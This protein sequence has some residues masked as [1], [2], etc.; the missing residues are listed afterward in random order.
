[1]KILIVE[2]DILLGDMLKE[3]L[4]H[5]EHERVE[6]STTGRN[7]LKCIEEE[8]FDCVFV[9]L[10]LPDIF[11]V[12]LLNE[13]KRQD[14]ALPVIMM[15]GHPTMD[16]AMDAMRKGA[17]DFLTKPFTLQNLVLTLERVTKE[18]KLLMENLR[19][20]WESQT[21][22]QL[23]AVNQQLQERIQEQ[24]RLF[25]IA[26][27]LDEI[28]SDGDLYGRVA[29]ISSDIT[30]SPN[31]AVFLLPPE[32]DKLVLLAGHGMDG[33]SG[34]DCIFSAN[35]LQLKELAFE[36]AYPAACPSHEL[37]GSPHLQKYNLEDATLSC[38]PLKI[39]GELFGF[40]MT[41]RDRSSAA[42]SASQLKLMDFLTR[43]TSLA[44]ENLA[45]YENLISNFYGILRSLVNALEAKDPYTGKHSERV[46]L[47]A[48]RIALSM[49]SSPASI[50]SL[51][52]A[53]YLHDIGKMG[54]ADKIL[55][56]PS[57]LTHEEFELIKK[58][59]VIGETI[60]ADLGLS[61]EERSII[62][63]HHERWDGRGYPHGLR[64]EEIPQ[65]A[66]IVAVADA[67]DAMTSK[68]AY[69][70][71]LSAKEALKEI[72][73]NRGTQFA[74]DVVDAFREIMQRKQKE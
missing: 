25:E 38:W 67:F 16:Y 4:Q 71:A 61:P 40:L 33:L 36:E 32:K 46:T 26:R 13:I 48:E 15:S 72:I 20:K 52:T 12:D 7:A 68:R 64:G 1:M 69:R 14:P 10:N 27:D 45:L 62:L 49:G 6:V 30:R 11:G 55:N 28:H 73:D 24:T 2:D 43:K 21:R 70:K 53:G 60:V 8:L 3:S 66:R 5:L 35:R 56:K 23:E 58:H 59:P 39:R 22:R 50:E 19:L 74:P 54:I 44:M 18:K 29:Q 47:Y 17:S 63:H 31:V 65:P 34:K 51:R 9:D 41:F 37:I 57:A 42:L